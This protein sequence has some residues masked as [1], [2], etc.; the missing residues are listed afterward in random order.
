MEKCANSGVQ[1]LITLEHYVGG[2]P[3][4]TVWRTFCVSVCRC[5]LIGARSG[6]ENNASKWPFNVAEPR[7]YLS[8]DENTMLSTDVH[9]LPWLCTR[10][11]YF[12]FMIHLMNVSGRSH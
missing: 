9:I 4:N 12:V 10:D 6:G 3:L 11:V 8:S 7:S 2:F 1:E 5:V